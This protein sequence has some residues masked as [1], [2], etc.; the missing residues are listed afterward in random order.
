MKNRSS[1]EYQNFTKLFLKSD[2]LNYL[3]SIKTGD[4]KFAMLFEVPDNKEI[5]LN[6]NKLIEKFTD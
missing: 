1:G 6:S 4:N 5:C 3:Y 2:T